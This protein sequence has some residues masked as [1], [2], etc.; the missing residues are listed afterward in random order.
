MKGK[1]PNRDNLKLIIMVFYVFVRIIKTS[2]FEFNASNR[3]LTK[4][5]H[6]LNNNKP[7]LIRSKVKLNSILRVKGVT[8]QVW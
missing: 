4:Q 7:S 1:I 3:G 8:Q 5:G 2:F 6:L